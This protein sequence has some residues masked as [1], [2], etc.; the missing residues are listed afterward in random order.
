MHAGSAQLL[1]VYPAE[2]KPDE[3]SEHRKQY[4]EASSGPHHTIVTSCLGEPSVEC[5]C[6][7]HDNSVLNHQNTQTL[8]GIKGTLV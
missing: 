4:R 3:V 2:T 8:T 1:T 5:V 7:W 6:A